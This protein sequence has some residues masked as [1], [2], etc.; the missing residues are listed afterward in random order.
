MYIESMDHW[1]GSTS[2]M[3]RLFSCDLKKE[4]EKGGGRES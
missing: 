3:S 4:R 1:T 2:H